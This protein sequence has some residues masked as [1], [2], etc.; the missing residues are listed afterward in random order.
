MKK[1]KWLDEEHGKD[2][3]R[4]HEGLE[5]QLRNGTLNMGND[6]KRY[7]ATNNPHLPNSPTI[8]P[9]IRLNQTRSS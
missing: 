1:P 7:T 4:V 2:R 6:E 8:L 5:H 9:P 3:E